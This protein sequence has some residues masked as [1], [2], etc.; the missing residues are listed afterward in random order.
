MTA[1][2]LNH[3]LQRAGLGHIE[4]AKRFGVNAAELLVMICPFLIQVKLNYSAIFFGHIALCMG[5]AFL[6]ATFVCRYLLKHFIQEI[7][8][9]KNVMIQSLEAEVKAIKPDDK[10]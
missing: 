9:Q 7:V 2:E 6:L 4:V 10:K 1:K 5:L 8:N 3:E